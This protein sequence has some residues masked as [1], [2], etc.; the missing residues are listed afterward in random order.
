MN[1]RALYWK[2]IAQMQFQNF[3][4]LHPSRCSSLLFT[5]RNWLSPM[6]SQV[7]ELVQN[8]LWTDTKDLFLFSSNHLVSLRVSKNG[9]ISNNDA[10]LTR[11]L[12]LLMFLWLISA[13][14][15]ASYV[16]TSIVIRA[17]KKR[18]E[19]KWGWMG[20][21]AIAVINCVICFNVW[22]TQIKPH[23]PMAFA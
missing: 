16:Y 10:A 15:K 12:C 19:R 4:Q 11:I 2:C 21:N 17:I 8:Q 18:R 9:Q 14:I 3:L 6:P 13:A 7:K 22:T 20:E 23:F 5:S 1:W